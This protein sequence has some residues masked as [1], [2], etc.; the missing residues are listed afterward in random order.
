VFTSDNSRV[1]ENI[2]PEK[3]ETQTGLSIYVDLLTDPKH[4]FKYFSAETVFKFPD[5]VWFKIFQHRYM[6]ILKYEKKHTQ[7]ISFFI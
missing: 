6:V 4:F 2:Y 7:F 1:P 3:S 5:R